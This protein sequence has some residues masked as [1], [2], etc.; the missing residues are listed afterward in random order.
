MHHCVFI[1]ILL[2][3]FVLLFKVLM[4][5][6]D[7][8]MSGAIT[9]LV[10]RGPEDIYLSVNIDKYVPDYYG[11]NYGYNGYGYNYPYSCTSPYC[12]RRFG[13]RTPFVWNN[14]TR[15]PKWYNPMYT[16][17]NDWY[18]DSYFYGLY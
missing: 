4:H 1:I 3:I 7:E 11:Y 15:Y 13:R 12:N 18:R 14:P 10:S 17:L 16:Y 5:D 6:C 2:V 9:Q 8:H